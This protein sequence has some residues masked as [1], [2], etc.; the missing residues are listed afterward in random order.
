MTSLSLTQFGTLP[1]ICLA[2]P[3]GGRATVTLFGGHVVSWQTA[4]GRER[5]FC[6]TRS[7]RDGSGAI[8]GGVPVIFP[9]FSER[10]P[11]KRHGFARVST[12]RLGES[13]LD[14]A[15]AFAQL[16]LAPA[17]LPP[18]LAAAWPA[19]FALRLRLTLHGQQLATELEVT[20]CDTAPFD[21]AAALHSYFAVG[22]LA[23][24]ALEGL[25]GLPYDDQSAAKTPQPAGAVRFDGQQLD[26]IYYALPAPLTIACGDSSLRLE[27]QGFTDAV[28]WNPGA[29]DA[30][31]LADL[32][33]DEY[34]RFVCVES[35]L[36]G[37]QTL[38]PGARW[39]GRQL[40]QASPAAQ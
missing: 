17:D 13:G 32:A 12:W 21:F 5:L 4:D 23:N 40:L 19:A 39:Q 30:A 27:Q 35:A 29:T 14:G 36:L 37:P 3:D 10:G 8:R 25:D 38:A 7:A 18:A 24:T 2:A 33:D 26:R 9:Q 34:V 20:N 22:D 11:G 16:H 28:V 15:A 6:S 1:A 31:A